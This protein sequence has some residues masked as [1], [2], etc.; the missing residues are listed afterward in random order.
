MRVLHFIMHLF[1]SDVS[2][3]SLAVS[4]SGARWRHR[5][6]RWGLQLSQNQ[7][8]RQAVTAA[9]VARTPSLIRIKFCGSQG[10][11]RRRHWAATSG[12]IQVP[13]VATPK[14]AIISD[15]GRRRRRHRA[16]TSGAINKSQQRLRQRELQSQIKITCMD[17]R[18]RDRAATFTPSH[19]PK[20]APPSQQNCPREHISDSENF[21]TSS[22]LLR[23]GLHKGGHNQYWSFLL[24]SFKSTSTDD[25][26]SAAISLVTVSVNTLFAIV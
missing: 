3:R 10:R 24:A 6:L 2:K 21:S 26:S 25:C 7:L 18:R 12:A 4:S 1:G 22:P 17:G 9:A 19:P 23:Q 5:P 16:A 14:R 20:G 8:S 11:R 13:T 15:Q